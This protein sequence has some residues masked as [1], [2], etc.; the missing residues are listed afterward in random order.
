[1]VNQVEAISIAIVEDNLEFA[2]LL[3][4][5]IAKQSGLSVIGVANHGEE[6]MNSIRKS[7]F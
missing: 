6:S 5:Y 4:E 3:A 1:M 2:E 7:S